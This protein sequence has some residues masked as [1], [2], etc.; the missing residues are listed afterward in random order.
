MKN[1]ITFDKRCAS[2]FSGQ[3]G[4]VR[5]TCT[6]HRYGKGMVLHLDREKTGPDDI[7]KDRASWLAQALGGRWARGHQ[8][9]YRIAPTR[10]LQFKL[11]FEAGWDAYSPIYSENTPA[12]FHLGNGPRVSLRVAL[13][14]LKHQPITP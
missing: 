1:G 12:V 14:L 3:L 6:P 11:L 8:E 9:G 13:E 2:T 4:N 5:Y 10:A 7:F